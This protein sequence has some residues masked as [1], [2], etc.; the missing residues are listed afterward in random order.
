MYSLEVRKSVEE[1]FS[2]L[3]KR[4]PK[5]LEIINKKI[6]QIRQNPHRFKLLHSPLTGMR[7]VHIDKSFVLVYS[8]D[9][10][11][12]IV[13]VEEYDHHDRVYGR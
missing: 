6:Q 12:K 7:R 5:Q 13:V 9:E 2:K 3:A 4:S 10:N 1:V 11:R 8:I